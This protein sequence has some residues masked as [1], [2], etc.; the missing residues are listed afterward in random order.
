MTRINIVAF[1]HFAPVA[2]VPATR[3]AIAEAAATAGTVGTILVAPEG[4][5]GT[6][7]GSRAGVD[8][9]L[10]HLRG[11]PG[12]AALET[13]LSSA[14]A[15]PFRRMKVRAK[16]EIVSMGVDGI[17]AARGKGEYVAP[18]DWDALVADPDT[19][20]IDARNAYEV[21]IGSFPGAID[22]GT[23][24]FRD[25]PDWFDRFVATLPK[26]D[27]PTIAMFCTGGIR[28]EKATAYARS[29]G[30]GDV[31]HLKGGILKYLE[32]VPAERS[33]WQGECFL[34]DGRVAVGQGLEQ[35]D[36]ALCHACRR[37]V[38]AADRA[39]P[40][41]AEGVSCPACHD[42]RSD[43]QRARY[44][45]RQRQVERAAANGTRHLAEPDL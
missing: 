28:C 6:I 1:Y 43:E 27:P 3:A 2:D 9:V 44:R 38:S 19:I 11:L 21:G 18:E 41:Y 31:R 33:G 8:A 13:K 37:P 22:P 26:D 40:E 4:L 10:A 36:H 30:F 14:A 25:F 34:F 45:E 12:F 42:E 7:A 39:S 15:A 5:N 24:S 23:A 32:S 17:D 16:A 29:K 20:V 35:G